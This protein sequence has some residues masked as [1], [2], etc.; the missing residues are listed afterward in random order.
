MRKNNVPL[1][2]TEELQ[3]NDTIRLGQ[4]TLRFVAFCSDDFTWEAAQPDTTHRA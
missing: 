1:L 3:T 2:S 4:T